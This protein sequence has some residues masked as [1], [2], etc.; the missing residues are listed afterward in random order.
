MS[1]RKYT[2]TVRRGIGALLRLITTSLPSSSLQAQGHR[3]HPTTLTYVRSLTPGQLQELTE[4]LNY[5]NSEYQSELAKFHLSAP[6]ALTSCL[7]FAAVS[8]APSTPSADLPESEPTTSADPQTPS[9]EN[10][11]S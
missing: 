10:S 4:C 6:S 9:P 1:T 7:L 11:P 8:S 5:L 3:P 2:S